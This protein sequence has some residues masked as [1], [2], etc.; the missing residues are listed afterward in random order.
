MSGVPGGRRGERL[1]REGFGL[2][3][4]DKQTAGDGCDCWSS[5]RQPRQFPSRIKERHRG[6]ARGVPLCTN[7]GS[8]RGRSWSRDGPPKPREGAA[9]HGG[10]RK[11]KTA[12]GVG[13]TQSIARKGQR[14]TFFFFFFYVFRSFL[15]ASDLASL[16]CGR[17]QRNPLSSL[18]NVA[19]RPDSRS[20]SGGCEGKKTSECR[21][22]GF[23]GA[24]MPAALQ[25]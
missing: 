4:T 13:R 23:S 21:V 12:G 18:A 3:W 15:H 2:W 20:V 22:Q 16:S 17:R 25:S 6:C 24:G 19:S 5:R 9:R 8:V 1:S 10:E 11:A 7:E 14:R